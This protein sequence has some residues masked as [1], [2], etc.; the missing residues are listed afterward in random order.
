MNNIL[1]PGCLGNVLYMNGRLLERLIIRSPET[2]MAVHVTQSRIVIS[3]AEFH[4]FDL[5]AARI[6][7]MGCA[8]G[9]IAETAPYLAH[10]KTGLR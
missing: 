5:R 7:G 6:S 1:P 10:I 3:I 8:A 9:S 4:D 2:L